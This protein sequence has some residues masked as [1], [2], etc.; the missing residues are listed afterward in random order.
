MKWGQSDKHNER[1][2][3]QDSSGSKQHSAGWRVHSLQSGFDRTAPLVPPVFWWDILSSVQCTEFSV[4][5][6]RSCV[7]T[8]N[9]DTRRFQSESKYRLLVLHPETVNVIS[10][11]YFKTSRHICYHNIC[12]SIY[13]I[14]N[15]GQMNLQMIKFCIMSCG[16]YTNGIINH[17]KCLKTKLC[18]STRW[19]KL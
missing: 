7:S 3:N 13:G 17:Q 6:Y 15:T 8:I 19:V 4:Q 18:R 12:V 16:L 2:F 10:C 11:N 1:K 9:N 14:H 5:Y